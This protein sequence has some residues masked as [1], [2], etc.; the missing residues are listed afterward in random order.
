M[1]PKL[2]KSRTASC[3]RRL[4]S[5]S[6]FHRHQTSLFCAAT[7]TQE[8]VATEE[9]P[10][11]KEF[12]TLEEKKLQRRALDQYKIP[13]F[14]EFLAEKNLTQEFLRT[15]T[16]VLQVNIG[17]YCNQTCNHCHV[18]SSP[19]RKEMMDRETADRLLYL[20]EKSDSIKI[21]DITGG[22]P[23]LVSCLF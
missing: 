2:L 20:L 19:K 1:L 10:S 11:L 16:S 9:I 21:V 18:E 17:L 4:G 23:E 5:V 13:D 3:F 15:E 7:Q 6:G 22:A 8:R 14:D 12:L